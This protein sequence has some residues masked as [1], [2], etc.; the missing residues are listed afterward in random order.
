MELEDQIQTWL[1][2]ARAER[3]E[4][5]D[6]Q[7]GVST[8]LVPVDEVVGGGEGIDFRARTQGWGQPTTPYFSFS[9]QVGGKYHFRKRKE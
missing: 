6:F 2:S 1:N 3:V 7:S 8:V 4:P 5:Q 9:P